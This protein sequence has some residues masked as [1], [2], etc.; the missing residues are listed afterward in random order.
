LLLLFVLSLFVSATLL[1]WIEP[2]FAKMILPMLGGSPA[3]WNTCIVFY[4]AMLLAGYVYAHVTT[5]LLKIRL[6]TIFHLG[7]LFLV[8]FTL[9]ISISDGWTPPVTSNPIPWLFLL[10]LVSIGLPFFAISTNAPLLQ[11]WFSTTRHPS[12]KDPYFLYSASNLGSMGALLGY[13]FFIERYLSL[14]EQ[15]RLWTGG[16]VF[17]AGLISV[18]AVIVLRSSRNRES[19]LDSGAVPDFESIALADHSTGELKVS[20]RIRWVLLSFAPSSLLL[21][22]TNYITTD[23]AQVP[24]LW[25]I[26]L[27]IYLLTFILVFATKPILPY[28]LMVRAQPLLLLPIMIPFYWGF[29]IISWVII[30]LHLLAFFVTA[31]V[32]H[33]ELANSRPSTTHLTEFYLWLSVGGVLGG[34]FNVIVAP[35]TFD[36]LAEYP[37][38]IVLACL[39]RP[40]LVPDAA[41]VYRRWLDVG[42]PLITLIVFGTARWGFGKIMS[43]GSTRLESIPG[44]GLIAVIL[45][46]CLAGVICL[47]FSDRPIRFGLC[48]GGLMLAGTLCAPGQNQLLYSERNFFG[49]LKVLYEPKSDCHLLFHGTTIHGAQSRNPALS[50]EPLTYYH[51]T[52]P[53]GQV[54]ETPASGKSRV[55]I[56]GL[57]TG[58]IA[59]YG[60]PGQLFTF[61]EIDPAVERIARD[62][63]YFTFVS[64]CPAKVDVV[65]GDAR[66][67]L[68]RTP[69][70][71]YDLIIL[72]AF[73]SDS[74]P[75]HLLTREAIK[76]YLKKLA[77][78][79]LLAFHV[80]NRYLN[81]QPILGDLAQDAGLRC[82][83]QEDRKVSEA[84]KKAKKC[85]SDWVVMASGKSD[86]GKL[87][88]DPRWKTLPGRP[89][90][91]LWTDDFS[92]VL[93]VFTGFTFTIPRFF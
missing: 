6:Q 23:I 16:Y 59:C 27:A 19:H 90:T 38:V 76:L 35:V 86:L 81:L 30:P 37:L 5:R 77:N 9:P 84:E 12:A 8:F 25:V 29:T 40:S 45:V 14:A 17:W 62:K 91:R 42:L 57:G 65:L 71:R 93:S 52:G 3:V 83:V 15:S 56:I 67:S 69:D 2:L 44:F 10:L 55:A 85:P 7:L 73:S 54:F 39:L 4:Q 18:C 63:R 70:H 89:G 87:I 47:S 49:I 13:P 74:I 48:L 33:G 41:K 60:K 61:Y 11:K 20:Q 75:I 68:S 53:L 51:R 43:L 66:L 50:R 36:S 24:L 46:S 82:L 88:E 58:S 28:K 79:G 92:N 78:K 21:G 34:L 22:V 64:E 32:C 26:P 72:D 80:S 31:M 1:F